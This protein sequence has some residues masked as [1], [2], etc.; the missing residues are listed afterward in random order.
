MG[1]SDYD[2]FLDS[3]RELT[4]DPANAGFTR[5]NLIALLEV[6]TSH[7][8]EALASK[9]GEL[10]DGTHVETQ[11]AVA[12]LLSGLS[13][14]LR[15]LDN[16]LT[17]PVLQRIAGKKNAAR[18]WRLRQEDDL[19]FEALEIF[20]RIKRLPDRKAAARRLAVTLQS[21]DYRRKEK[22]LRG[23]NL[24]ALYNKYKYQ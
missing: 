13:S 19:L 14:A 18:P 2:A 5:P 6:L 4:A 24:Y 23:S 8:D 12:D 10:E 16:G 21:S 1:A 17:D 20:Q 7:L 11:H 3:L 9:L 15:D 22:K